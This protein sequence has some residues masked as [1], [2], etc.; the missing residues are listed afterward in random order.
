MLGG[1]N[2]N[3]S[4]QCVVSSVL[5]LSLTASS[6][7][8]LKHRWHSRNKKHTCVV[9]F[10]DYSFFFGVINQSNMRNPTKVEVPG[11]STQIWCACIFVTAQLPFLYREPYASWIK[12]SLFWVH[13]QIPSIFHILS[14]FSWQFHL[15]RG[16]FESI[17]QP[18]TWSLL[19]RKVLGFIVCIPGSTDPVK[20]LLFLAL[21]PQFYNKLSSMV[22]CIK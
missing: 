17:N 1:V 9:F 11:S 21:R 4:R 7:P 16:E 18:T 15:S 13:P 20:I 10:K 8:P 2:Q 6:S 19:N 3:P 5:V 22:I 14:W 12:A